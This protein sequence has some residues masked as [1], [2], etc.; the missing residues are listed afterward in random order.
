MDIVGV[1]G[2]RILTPRAINNYLTAIQTVCEGDVCE[3]G[4]WAI[5]SAA[6]SVNMKETLNDIDTLA[7]LARGSIVLTRR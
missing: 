5:E 2:L 4:A 3:K 6:T 1:G 7:S